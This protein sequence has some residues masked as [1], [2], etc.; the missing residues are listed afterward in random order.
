[1]CPKPFLKL[2]HKKL[3]NLLSRI[4][5]PNYLHSGVKRKSYV[6]NGRYHA[7]PSSYA[8]T[9]DL[10]KFY[11]S[12]SKEFIFK[13]FKYNFNMSDDVAWLVTDI[14]IYNGFLPTGSPVSQLIAFFTYQRTFDKINGM[15]EKR[16]INFSLYVDDMAF[17]SNKA[18]PNN[19]ED[20]VTKEFE[21]VGLKI[22]HEKTRKYTKKQIKTI[23]GCDIHPNGDLKV[24]E[25]RRTEIIQ[26]F[27][28]INKLTEQEKKSLLGKIQAARQIEPNIFE[29]ERLKLSR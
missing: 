15:A 1:M 12:S 5:T 8:L 11:Q 6:T 9:L 25:K 20:L 14:V 26:S 23:T 18:I 24:P 21:N 10:S 19:M 2:V 16:H 22:K 3:A 29:T 28:R 13:A 17:S 4:E 7:K 27:E